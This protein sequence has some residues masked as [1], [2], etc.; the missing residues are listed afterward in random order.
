MSALEGWGLG[1]S[2]EEVADEL[3]RGNVFEQEMLDVADDQQDVQPSAHLEELAVLRDVRLLVCILCKKSSD[4][5]VLEFPFF[6]PS[7]C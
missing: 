7:H 3:S 6:I 1:D 5:D 4:Q 2:D